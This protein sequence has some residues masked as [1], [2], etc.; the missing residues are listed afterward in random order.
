MTMSPFLQP[1]YQGGGG[2]AGGRGTIMSKV[3]PPPLTQV[4]VLKSYYSLSLFIYLSLCPPFA[5]AYDVHT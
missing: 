2:E 5:Y 3:L 4:L 1:A